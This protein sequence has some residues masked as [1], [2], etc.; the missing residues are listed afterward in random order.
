MT[1]AQII[2]WAEKQLEN[3]GI[4]VSFAKRLMLDMC[5]LQGM[6]LYLL[7]HDEI[8]N[9]FEISYKEKVE[10][11]CKNEPLAYVLGVEWFYS[12][13]FHVDSRVLIPREET[14]EL[15]GEML[16]RM[17]E[18][19]NK[20]Q[21]LQLVDIGTGSGCCGITLAKEANQP[22]E[23]SLTDISPEA[24]EVAQI[25][26]DHLEQPATLYL[27]D[28]AKP[29]IEANKRFDV[30]LCN[31]PYILNGEEVMSSVLEYEPHVALFGGEDGLDFYRSLLDDLHH[32]R[33]PKCL[34]G[35]EMGYQQKE[36]LTNEI[37]KRYPNQTL[38]FVKDING[39]DRMCF[40]TLID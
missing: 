22:V 2:T 31:P 13:Y 4:T 33:K 24:L 36:N 25:N 9:D 17:D 34:V 23:L 18:L 32:I 14:Q 26:C 27:G 12:R 39:L 28:M 21:T 1:F 35:F 3:N 38:E 20:E 8:E 29:L 16:W 37:K 30:I 40:L 10:R 5:E 11:L 19:F 6:N 15:M 7:M